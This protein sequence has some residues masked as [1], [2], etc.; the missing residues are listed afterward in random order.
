MPENMA[1]RTP[2]SPPA[3]NLAAAEVSA[4]DMM[5]AIANEYKVPAIRQNL[6]GHEG[7]G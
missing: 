1:A 7:L 4:K 2:A 5:P 6:R 3:I